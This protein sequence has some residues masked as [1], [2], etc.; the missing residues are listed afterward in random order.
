MGNKSPVQ[1]CNEL[2]QYAVN[3]KLNG[4]Q[5]EK[6][7]PLLNSLFDLFMK[8]QLPN[9]LINELNLVQR[10]KTKVFDEFKILALYN[11]MD[12]K[13]I[14]RLF[15]VS[16]SDLHNLKNYYAM[17]YY[18]YPSREFVQLKNKRPYIFQGFANKRSI[19]IYD[20][21]LEA[22]NSIGDLRFKILSA[23]NFEINILLGEEG[24]RTKFYPDRALKFVF[25]KNLSANKKVKV[26]V[27]AKKSEILSILNEIKGRKKLMPSKIWFKANLTPLKQCF[28]VTV[29]SKALRKIF[30]NK[31]I[32]SVYCDIRN[33]YVII[34]PS[35]F[36]PSRKSNIANIYPSGKICFT[37]PKNKPI[38]FVG[39]S[40]IAINSMKNFFQTEEELK[41][42][43]GLLRKDYNILAISHQQQQDLKILHVAA[44][45]ITALAAMQIKN[46]KLNPPSLGHVFG[47]LYKCFRFSSRTSKKSFF[48]INSHWKKHPYFTEFEGESTTAFSEKH[49]THIIF[50]DYCND[51][52]KNV[53][54]EIEAHL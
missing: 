19:A 15:T 40:G 36:R 18:K 5:S 12:F 3:G 28:L 27:Y 22:L 13:E 21:S 52:Q 43:E 29:N 32:R 2:W 7:K 25:P 46:I 44:D 24:K 50:T 30:C 38:Q 26:K 16:E 23:S 20:V 1:I 48:L 4:K 37:I 53:I 51:W 33:N 35:T 39:I 47:D 31:G 49:N 42:A 8:R 34:K 11:E 9:N 54:S 17:H 45:D 41:V 14:Y 6:V 10:G